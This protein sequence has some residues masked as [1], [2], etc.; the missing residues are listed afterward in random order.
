LFLQ[1]EAHT[2]GGLR[3]FCTR[4]PFLSGEPLEAGGFGQQVEFGEGEVAHRVGFLEGVEGSRAEL[5]GHHGVVH[6]HAVGV[7]VECGLGDAGDGQILAL[8]PLD[9]QLGALGGHGGGVPHVEQ[10]QAAGPE[11]V[12][13]IGEHGLHGGVGGLV[14]HHMEE[15]QHSI[16]AALQLGGGD[17][18]LLAA[19]AWGLLGGGHHGGAALEAMHAVA[20]L[21]EQAAVA[22]GAGAELQQLL[23][24]DAVAL[25]EG[26]H[27]GG[28]SSGIFLLVEE[29][30]IAAA[31]FE[32]IGH[33]LITA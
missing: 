18:A 25:E 21:G 12:G 5:L 30:V 7:G 9:A 27:V 14:A 1:H 16:E 8:K 32:G 20:A 26:I 31:R 19:E 6:V 33:G 28:F 22:A 23:A 4:E 13:R 17:V 2:P 11:V 15:G 24:A 29:V 3:G 10:E